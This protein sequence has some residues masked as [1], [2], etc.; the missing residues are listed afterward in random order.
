MSAY[1]RMLCAFMPSCE[2]SWI[3][4]YTCVLTAAAAIMQIANPSPSGGRIN[5]QYRQVECAPPSDLVVN[6]NN[7]DGGNGWIR[8]DISVRKVECTSKAPA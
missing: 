2:S 3:C 5:V 1:E 4:Y 7:N 6:V 8:L